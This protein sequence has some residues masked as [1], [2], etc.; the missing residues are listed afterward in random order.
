MEQS[1][2]LPFVPV[3]QSGGIGDTIVSLAWLQNVLGPKTTLPV[4]IYSNF[5][6]I[7]SYFLPW[8]EVGGDNAQFRR[9]QKDFSWWL[10]ISDFIDFKG[11]PKTHMPDFMRGIFE[12]WL[13]HW[14]S[15]WGHLIASEPHK[16]N[17]MGKKAVELGL[18]RRSLTFYLTGTR[19]QPFW[20]GL[21]SPFIP[22]AAVP[23]R[24]I[25]VHDGFDASGHYKFPVSMKSWNVDLW[26]DFIARFKTKYPEIMVVQLGGPKRIDLPGVDL[27][28]AGQLSF[29]ETLRYLKSSIVH[30][31][32][33]SGLV[34]ARALFTAPSVVLFGP[35]NFT[36]FGYPGN[37]NLAPN[38]CGDCWWKKSDWMQNCVNG[39]ETNL[40]MESIRPV[41]VMAE[42][43]KFL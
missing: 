12:V 36:Y 17:E 35:T 1:L 24:F 9:D 22:P 30:V 42:V 26:A 15:G 2:S 27:N 7:I 6:E 40:C 25:T 38:V 4:R 32:G 18:N 33:D 11:D 37:I 43:E 28:L 19:Y 21:G 20:M 31:D 10:S 23:H 14:D 8:V 41:R 39:Y 3:Y 5:P 29:F 16:A 34:H 13:K